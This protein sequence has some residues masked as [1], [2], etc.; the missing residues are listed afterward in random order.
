MLGDG[1]SATQSAKAHSFKIKE[2]GKQLTIN[3][4][5]TPGIGDV[6]GIEKDKIN[7]QN[8]LDYVQGFNK[9]KTHQDHLLSVIF[10]VESFNFNEFFI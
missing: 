8:T 2:G 10:Y 7:F 4:I 1:Q 3:L 9:V 5:D 6:R